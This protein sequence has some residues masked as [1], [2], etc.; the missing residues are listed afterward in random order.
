MQHEQQGPE[1]FAGL[2]ADR[3]EQGAGFLGREWFS[4]GERGGCLYLDEAGDVAGDDL[5]AAG[6]FERGTQGGVRVRDGAL[7]LLSA[8]RAST[9][10]W[11]SLPDGAPGHLPCRSR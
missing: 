2:S 11:A 5:F 1:C 6:V 4:R 7:V 8:R 10:S 9:M 3:G